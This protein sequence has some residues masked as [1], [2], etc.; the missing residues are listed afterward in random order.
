MRCSSRRVKIIDH[1]IRATANISAV[2][3]IEVSVIHQLSLDVA[4]ALLCI[5]C[6]NN[7][8]LTLPLKPL[9]FSLPSSSKDFDVTDGPSN[10]IGPIRYVMYARRCM[11]KFRPRWKIL[12]KTYCWYIFFNPN[13]CSFEIRL[14]K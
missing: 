3:E 8:P 10:T 12:W 14:S 6:W 5:G 1:E 13:P 11:G 4:D 9:V 2:V 7:A